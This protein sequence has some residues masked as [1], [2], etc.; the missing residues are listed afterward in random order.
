VSVR[1]HRGVEAA[2][3]SELIRFR[4]AVA[5]IG[6]TLLLPGSAQLMRGSKP[7]GR[8]ALRVVGLVFVCLVGGYIWLGRDGVIKLGLNSTFLACAEA[9]LTVLAMC[10]VAL[11]ADAWRLG[12]PPTL[13]RTHRVLTAS[14]T[15]ALM[16]A[17]TVPTAWSARLL[18]TH[19]D[20]LQEVFEEGGVVPLPQGRLN[21]LLLGGDGGNN[22]EGIRT[23]SI[24]LASIDVGTG[25]TVLFSLP[26]NMQFVQFPPGS[27]MAERYPNGFPDFFFSIYTYAAD[28]PELYPK[29]KNPGARAV[30]EAVAQ[31]LGLDVHYYALVNLEGFRE[32]INALGGITL[33]VERRLPI[34]GGVSL[35][36][37]PQ[38]I[39]GYIEPGLQK[40]NGYKALWYARSRHG[41]DDYERMARQ[42]CVMG[43][44]LREAN[45]MT[46]LTHYQELAKSTKHVLTTNLTTGALKLLVDIAPK[47]RNADQ[48]SVQF[49]NRLINPAFPDIEFIRAKVADAIAKSEKVAPA[50]AVKATPKPGQKPKKK[51]VATPKPVD[52]T[53]PVAL[54]DACQYK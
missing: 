5:L 2:R 7:V 23:D 32:V 41:S 47:A 4:R 52:P 14:L 27:P 30:M 18:D 35:T 13:L 37:V 17:V 25:K 42:R 6:M 49:T 9:T 43:A 26:R 22:R 21:V 8:A 44:I 51:A 12:R 11:F 45:P 28:H 16:A 19:R 46:I 38:P 50:P 53:Q 20:V 48:T 39:V 33:R 40:L 31:T 54:K 3:R 10:W 34:G 29:S 24:T 1:T 36:G 15:L